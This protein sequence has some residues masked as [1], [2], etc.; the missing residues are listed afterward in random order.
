MEIDVSGLGLSLVVRARRRVRDGF[1]LVEMLVVV[2]TMAILAGILLPSLGSAKRRAKRTQCLNNIRQ[3]TLADLIYAGDHG[4]LPLPNEFVPSTTTVDRLTQIAGNLGMS[5]PSGPVASWPRR[6]GQPKWFNCPMAVDS[7]YAE[8]VTLGAGLY[9]GYAYVGALEDSKMVAMGFA[10]LAHPEHLADARN[11]RRGVLWL[12]VLD[13]FVMDDVRRF[14]FFH[15]RQ[16]TRYLDFRFPAAEL[17]GIHRAWSD[18]SVEW[19]TQRQIDLSGPSSRD[20]QIRHLLGN[21]YF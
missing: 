1:A 15:A 21:Y 10:S 8:G 12:D 3:L 11:L 14:E 18:G 4:R 2:A 17:E 7:G 19:V 20:L 9:T 5:V 13:E 6:A 16:R